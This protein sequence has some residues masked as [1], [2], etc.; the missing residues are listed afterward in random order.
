MLNA[1]T[2][3]P[4]ESELTDSMSISAIS[5]FPALDMAKTSILKITEDTAFLRSRVEALLCGGQYFDN[6]RFNDEIY[7]IIFRTTD[8]CIPSDLPSR[9][10]NTISL[11]EMGGQ[12]LHS[13]RFLKL[14][15]HFSFPSRL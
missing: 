13:S 5:I 10:G 14:P 1:W 2:I 8:L 11:R 3:F 9:S 7:T 12:T 4:S 15:L 6:L